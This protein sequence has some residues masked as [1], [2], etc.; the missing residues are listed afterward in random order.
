MEVYGERYTEE[1]C[2]ED[3]D[4][5]IVRIFDVNPMKKWPLEVSNVCWVDTSCCGC[6]L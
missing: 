6:H 4:T 3:V 5:Q 2:A 1:C